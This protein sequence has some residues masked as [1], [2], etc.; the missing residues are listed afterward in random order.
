MDAKSFADFMAKTLAHNR[1]IFDNS[2]VNGAYGNDTVAL[3]QAVGKRYVLDQLA[4]GMDAFLSNFYK[5]K[6]PG[7][8]PDAVSTVMDSLEV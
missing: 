8:V 5:E 4:T 7:M 2:L 3:N 1:S 6:V